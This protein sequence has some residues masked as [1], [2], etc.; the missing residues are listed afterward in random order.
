MKYRSSR[1]FYVSGQLGVSEQASDVEPYGN[2]IAV[3]SEFPGAFDNGDGTVGSIGF[4]Y[5]FNQNY[6]LE[7]RVGKR[8]GSFSDSKLGSGS[9][10]GEEYIVNGKLKSATFTVEAFYD[11]ANDTAF[12]PYV[13]V[14]LGIADNSYSARLGGAGVAAYDAYDGSVD[15]YYDAYA[16]DESSEFSWNA[17]FGANYALSQNVSLY[18]EYQFATFGEVKTGQDSF[19]DGFK[20]DDAA[21]HEMMIGIRIKL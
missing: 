12:T 10:D 18:G 4:G 11:F 1:W 6:R 17:G 13:K 20:I 16:D 14:G 2:N 15:G 5:I 21:A 9:R 19:T 7:G 8:D 3:D